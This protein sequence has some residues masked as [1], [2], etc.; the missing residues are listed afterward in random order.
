MDAFLEGDSIETELDTTPNIEFQL[1]KYNTNE[2][3]SKKQIPE[4][5]LFAP[6]IFKDKV[7]KFYETDIDIPLLVYGVPGCGKLTTVLGLINQMPGYCSREMNNLY[8][9]KILDNEH[10]KLLIYENLYYLN[11]ESLSSTTEIS[12]YLKYIYKI[13]KSKSIDGTKKIIIISHIEKCNEEALKYI[14]YILDKLN[15][16]TSYIF[17]TTKLNII[18]NKIKS[19]CARI[20]FSYLNENEFITIFKFNY[21]HIYNSKY[22]HN[23]YLKQYYQIYVNNNYN[24]GNT[25]NQI[26]YILETNQNIH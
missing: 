22:I 18:T 5:A 16:T 20:N 13:S 2:Y 26:K 12:Q 1:N 10:Q 25:L 14:N 4:S 17:I 21:K 7:K 9:M 8:H 15:A 19:T 3:I 6:T 24:I 23:T 11:M